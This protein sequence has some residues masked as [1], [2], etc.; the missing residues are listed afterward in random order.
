MYILEVLIYII[1]IALIWS[2][3]RKK[4]IQPRFVIIMIGTN[5]LL[6]ILHVIL[7]HFRI[8]FLSNLI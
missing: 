2:V 1:S 4:T 5:V 7:F 3:F 8:T 6:L